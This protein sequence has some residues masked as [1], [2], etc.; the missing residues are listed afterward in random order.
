MIDA[1]D[2]VI[3][4]GRAS[5]SSSPLLA[6][7][8]APLLALPSSSA[9]SIFMPESIIRSTNALNSLLPFSSTRPRLKSRKI[10]GAAPK[11]QNISVTRPFS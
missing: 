7:P 4:I 6:P 9:L 11:E 5:S 10:R 8:L 2:L 1:A 3:F